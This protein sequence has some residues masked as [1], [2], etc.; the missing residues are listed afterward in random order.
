MKTGKES[1][2]GKLQ[3]LRRVLITCQVFCVIPTLFPDF[4]VKEEIHTPVNRIIDLITVFLDIPRGPRV[5]GFLMKNT[6]MFLVAMG[7]FSDFNL[8]VR[9]FW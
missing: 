5:R 6:K 3:M 9:R 1:G 4:L 8:E 2:V 7:R